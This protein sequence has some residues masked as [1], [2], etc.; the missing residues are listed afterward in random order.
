MYHS[1]GGGEGDDLAPLMISDFS[2][3]S[4][5]CSRLGSRFAIELPA[6]S[7]FVVACSRAANRSTVE[8]SKF[9]F[10]VVSHTVLWI[11]VV[12]SAK[13]FFSSVTELVN[14]VCNSSFIF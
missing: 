14:W 3:S 13:T 1:L 10:A 9:D 11:S 6:A 2:K 12:T 8:M 7:T 5:M 4:S